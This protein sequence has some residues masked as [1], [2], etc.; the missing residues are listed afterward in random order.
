MGSPRTDLY[1]NVIDPIAINVGAENTPSLVGIICSCIAINRENLVP[2]EQYGISIELE[3]T[4]KVKAKYTKGDVI[5]YHFDT[6]GYKNFTAITSKDQTLDYA[7]KRR[8]KLGTVIICYVIE[9]SGNLISQT[10]SSLQNIDTVKHIPSLNYVTIDGINDVN[11]SMP[12]SL[13]FNLH[14]ATE[15]GFYLEFYAGLDHEFSFKILS[16]EHD[17]PEGSITKI[18]NPILVYDN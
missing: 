7:I 14:T 15:V 5:N 3:Y 16:V 17:F 11:I 8:V 1:I 18:S 10:Y 6:T 4:F 13:N 9:D 12:F 2:N